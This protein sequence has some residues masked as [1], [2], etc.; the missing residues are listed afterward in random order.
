MSKQRTAEGGKNLICNRLREVRKEKGLS[1][2]GMAEVLKDRGYEMDRNVI[3]RIEKN[4]RY[5]TDMEIKA[6]VEVLG[7]DYGYLIEGKKES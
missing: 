2:R 3:C 1:I 6:F 4:E 5:V 7:V